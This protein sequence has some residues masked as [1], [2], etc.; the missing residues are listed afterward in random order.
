M[1]NCDVVPNPPSEKW[2]RSLGDLSQRTES[3][4]TTKTFERQILGIW[5]LYIEKPSINLKWYIPLCPFVA[6]K[7]QFVDDLRYLWRAV[8]DLS[9][10]LLLA[11]LAVSAA[12][13][14]SPAAS[15]W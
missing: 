10:P 15:L 3:F 8:H 11:R 14:L 6:D 7:A 1:Q 9:G 13:A 5:E 2:G 12:L 4:G